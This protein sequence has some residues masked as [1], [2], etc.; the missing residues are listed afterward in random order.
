M[1]GQGLSR[2]SD[3]NEDAEDGESG[4]YEV[5]SVASLREKLRTAERELKKL[6]SGSGT[7]GSAP[8][9]ESHLAV[10][11]PA[12]DKGSVSSEELS[13]LQAELNDTRRLKQEREDAWMSA[14]KQLLE[15]QSEVHKLT[16]ANQ[17]LQQ[18]AATGSENQALTR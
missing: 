1:Q 3:N 7:A 12:T 14:K 15:A 16:R 9:S 11:A 10:Q 2:R 6:R 4:L 8:G 5:E 13:L 17:T 18:Q